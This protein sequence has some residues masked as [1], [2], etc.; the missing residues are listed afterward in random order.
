MAIVTNEVSTSGFSITVSNPPVNYNSPGSPGMVAWD[1]SFLYV[2]VA[3]NLWARTNIS[4][5]WG[6][7]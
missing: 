5:A 7:D 1:E 2:C 3:T 4:T 6:T